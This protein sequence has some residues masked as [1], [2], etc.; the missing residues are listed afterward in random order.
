MY[1]ECFQELATKTVKLDEIHP[2]RMEKVYLFFSDV[3]TSIS[4]YFI[5][6]VQGSK[7]IHA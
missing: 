5:I 7:L 6:F 4:L 1:D 3:N 2:K